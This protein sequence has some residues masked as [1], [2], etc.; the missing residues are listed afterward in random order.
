MSHIFDLFQNPKKKTKQR[1]ILWYTQKEK[2]INY[3]NVMK[4]LPQINGE[5]EKKVG[6]YSSDNFNIS[7]RNTL[8]SNFRPSESQCVRY[9]CQTQPFSG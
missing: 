3:K 9:W 2:E 6:L 1:L 7:S 8:A 4:G 5:A